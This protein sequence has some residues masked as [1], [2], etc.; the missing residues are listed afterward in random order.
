MPYLRPSVPEPRRILPSRTVRRPGLITIGLVLLCAGLL[1]GGCVTELTPEERQAREELLE[2]LRP[3]RQEQ[4]NR[5]NFLSLSLQDGPGR[6]AILPVI[7]YAGQSGDRIDAGCTGDVIALF[8]GL[9][10]FLSQDDELAFVIAHE[11]AHCL[12][13]RG[14]WV[15]SGVRQSYSSYSLSEETQA[16]AHALTYMYQAGFDV[17]IGVETLV[18]LTTEVPKS[19]TGSYFSLHPHVLERIARAKVHAAALH[20][21]LHPL[22]NQPLPP[23][24]QK[25]T[26]AMTSWVD[27]NRVTKESRWVQRFDDE[28]RAFVGVRLNEVQASKLHLRF[29]EEQGDRSAAERA[30]KESD[31]LVNK[32]RHEI[33]DKQ[34]EVLSQTS[35]PFHRTILQVTREGIQGDPNAR[36]AQL[37]DHKYLPSH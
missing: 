9:V 19:L 6:P 15:R 32:L 3:W 20:G 7:L 8:E 10:R 33:E 17:D 30:R 2:K 28:M 1:S 11:M 26:F 27:L 24:V 36:L 22:T 23:P 21:G 5:L 13:G 16:D 37:L 31:A 18:R 34:I 12:H 25:V 4:R 29:V 14:S 35:L